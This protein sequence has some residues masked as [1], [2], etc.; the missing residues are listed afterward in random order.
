MQHS[1]DNQRIGCS[2]PNLVV[3][4][5]WMVDHNGAF[6]RMVPDD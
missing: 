1:A 2:L 5:C 3:H 6:V 4:Q